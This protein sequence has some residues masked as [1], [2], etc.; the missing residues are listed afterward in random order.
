MIDDSDPVN[1]GSKQTR[2]VEFVAQTTCEVAFT[3]AAY[4]TA[5][6]QQRFTS[7]SSLVPGSRV[8]LTDTISLKLDVHPAFKPRGLR[9]VPYTAL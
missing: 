9:A 4:D 8:V 3:R 2:I 1:G 7:W 6:N 5:R